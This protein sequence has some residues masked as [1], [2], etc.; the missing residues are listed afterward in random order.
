MAE[1]HRDGG[2]IV[3]ELS[4]LEK[5]EAAHGNVRIPARAIRAI[6]VIDDALEAVPA[7]KA[8]GAR[9]PGWMAVGTFYS[10]LGHDRRKAF[11]VV[12]HTTAR[13]VHVTLS[14]ADYDELIIGCAD[15]EAVAAALRE[16]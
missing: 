16:S 9:V 8:P 13:A 10:G 1:L 6:T 5:A 11:V 7:L 14:G 15:P 4:T 12:H 3:V 2:D